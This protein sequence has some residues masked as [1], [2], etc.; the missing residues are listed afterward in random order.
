MDGTVQDYRAHGAS[1]AD[2]GGRA[3]AGDDPARLRGPTIVVAAGPRTV[4][5]SLDAKLAEGAGQRLEALAKAAVDAT[6]GYTGAPGAGRSPSDTARRPQSPSSSPSPAAAGEHADRADRRDRQRQVH[7]GC[8]VRRTGRGG[9]RRRP[10]GPAGAGARH[11]RGWRRCCDRFGADLAEPDGVLDR[12]RLAALVFADPAA[13]AD[14]NAIVH[15][16]V[17]QRTAE[18]TAAAGPDAVV[19]YDVPLLV[20]NQ[21]AGGFD[22]VVVVEAPLPSGWPGWPTGGWP[23]PRPG[24]GSPPRPP[25]SSAGR[26]PPWCWTTPARSPNYAPRS[27]SSGHAGKWH[28]GAQPGLVR[29]TASARVPCRCRCMAASG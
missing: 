21:L 16:L 1:P 27:M 14:L 20:E 4:A 28:G 2:R 10:A 13:L 9:D 5:V 18:L 12:A 25:T 19:V 17:A 24:P 7:R 26:W 8:P 15:P 22:A 29:Q 3:A 6:A 23:R 11:V